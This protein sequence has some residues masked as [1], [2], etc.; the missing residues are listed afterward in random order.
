MQKPNVWLIM[1]DQQRWDTLGC[2]GNPTIETANLDYFAANGTVFENGYSCT[3][4]CIPARA[5]L[6]TGQ[7]PWNVGILGMGAGQGGAQLLENT[8][9]ESLANAGYHTQC[10]G[11]MHVHPQ[12][13]LQGFH[14]TML[15][16]SSRVQDPHFESDYVKWFNR[17]RPADVDRQAHGIDWNSWM[18]RPWHLPEYLHPTAWTAAESIRFLERRD[19][20]KP[21][22]LKTSFARPHSP[23][24][25]PPY[26]FDLYDKKEMPEAVIGDWADV[27]DVPHDAADP[28]AWHG[29]R[30]PE[31]VRRARVGYYG[32]IHFIDH[33]I[34]VVRQYLKKQALFD[35]TLI[36]FVSDH[37]DM[38]GDHHLWRK[39][40]AYEG[41]A[42][43]PFLV[44]LPPNWKQE[45]VSRS[46][47]PL[48][49]QDVMPTILDACGVEIPA[50]VDGRSAL[51]LVRGESTPW[52]EFVHGEHCACYA[53]ENEMQYLTDGQWKY[54]WFT[55]TGEEQLFH[56]ENDRY[57]TQDLSSDSKYQDELRTW[58]ER[59][60]GVL[61]PRCAGLVESGQLVCQRDEPPLIS[62]HYAE[63]IA[64]MR[65]KLNLPT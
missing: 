12:R 7:D 57:E 26:Y 39:T 30:K 28:N 65:E 13:S 1:T 23:Y 55:R 45:V 54:I 24:D 9:P 19:P 50:T 43:I 25:A 46:A 11:K 37:G 32:N 5:S 58:R 3:P 6:L 4:S 47:A 44:S 38:M 51:P 31:E 33:Q 8:L 20:T 59:M 34:G 52:R 49:L 17:N 29:K 56:L 48:C 36:I 22:F 15:D 16:E 41:S 61:Q 40:Y 27:H 18:A 64:R 60:I 42:H 21:F 53:P 63:R 10:V 2:Y 35:N 62:P 14:G